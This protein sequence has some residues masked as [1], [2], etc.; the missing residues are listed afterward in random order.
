[1]YNMFKDKLQS[2]SLNQCQ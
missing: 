1:M 2:R